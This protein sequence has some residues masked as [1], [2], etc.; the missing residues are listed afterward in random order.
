VAF[1]ADVPAESRRGHNAKVCAVDWNG[2]G[3]LDLLVGDFATQQPDLPEPTPGEQAAWNRLARDRKAA[4]ER[5]GELFSKLQ[6]AGPQ[7]REQLIADLE[8][9][10]EELARLQ[11]QFPPE[12]ETHGWV[13][14]FLRRSA[15]P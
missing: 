1:G 13:W 4:R 15:K 3:R 14:L 10:Q 7:E 9:T 6:A 8:K 11:E 12:Y 2:D 5:Y